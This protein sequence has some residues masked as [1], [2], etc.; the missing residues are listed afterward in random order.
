MQHNS[1]FDNSIPR[2]YT[3]RLRREVVI[4]LTSEKLR[5]ERRFLRYRYCPVV[6]IFGVLA[7]QPCITITEYQISQCS[8]HMKR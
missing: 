4:V 6:A 1:A 3:N 5:T 7:D 2:G 8:S